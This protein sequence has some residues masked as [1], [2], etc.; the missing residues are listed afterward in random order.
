VKCFNC[1]SENVAD[2]IFCAICG[3]KLTSTVDSCPQC[4]SPLPLNATFCHICGTRIPDKNTANVAFYG[5]PVPVSG[6]KKKHRI[7]IDALA[8]LLIIVITALITANLAG[9]PVDDNQGGETS[10]DASTW[11]ITP[12]TARPTTQDSGNTDVLSSDV[13]YIDVDT[14][15]GSLPGTG[16]FVNPWSDKGMIRTENVEGMRYL[17]EWYLHAVS[18]ITTFDVDL[19]GN[20]ED[21]TISIEADPALHNDN[22][23]LNMSVYLITKG[24]RINL[25]NLV[26]EEFHEMRAIILESGMEH[27]NNDQTGLLVDS[28]IGISVICKDLD[29]DGLM[30]ILLAVGEDY[31]KLVVSVLKYVGGNYYYQEVGGFKG[32]KELRFTTISEKNTLF[33]RL[34]FS[35][36]D[37][38]YYF[39]E[40]KYTGSGLEVLRYRDY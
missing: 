35:P 8:G 6:M 2:S 16:N 36:D 39:V 18:P 10:H 38:T 34:Y 26:S 13:E 23:F 32:T 11:T 9:R 31:G 19:D 4:R 7:W 30:E 28:W 33:S 17:A 37:S 25:Y 29:G 15:E 27:Y 21:E 20:G 5:Q 1:D 24:S 22:E 40:F 3:T 12:T 14:I